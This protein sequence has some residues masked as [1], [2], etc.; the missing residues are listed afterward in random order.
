MKPAVTTVLAVLFIL[1]I[2]AH[3]APAAWI[4]VPSAEPT[5]QAGIDAAV[6]GDVVLVAPGTYVENIDFDYKS[7]EVRS[8]SGPLSTTIDGNSSGSVVTI[9]GDE[10]DDAVL[11]GF[12]LAYGA[13]DYGGGIYISDGSDATIRDC[14]IG[15]NKTVTAYPVDSA[16]Y[17]M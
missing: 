13:N 12:T 7:I 10:T 14:Q 15:Y 5:I 9:K 4:Q 8:E 16:W 2:F 17:N 1:T 3:P 6:D 11:D